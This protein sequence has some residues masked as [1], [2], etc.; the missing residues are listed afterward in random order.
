MSAKELESWKMPRKYRREDGMYGSAGRFA[1]VANV[2]NRFRIYEYY[3]SQKE[4][5]GAIE[6]LKNNEILTACDLYVVLLDAWIP[7]PFEPADTTTIMSSRPE[8]N[9]FQA[10]LDAVNSETEQ[11]QKNLDADKGNGKTAYELYRMSI[12]TMAMKFLQKAAD[13]ILENSSGLSLS[14]SRSAERKK[15]EYDLRMARFASVVSNMIDK[16]MSKD[17]MLEFKRLRGD[18]CGKIAL[19]STLNKQMHDLL[20]TNDANQNSVVITDKKKKNVI[21]TVIPE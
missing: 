6:F 3:T 20:N 19:R 8:K 15:K 21:Q 10:H 14:R 7:V 1:I 9:P 12:H 16:T 13:K 11:V 2:A 4:A 18:D 5:E 17:T